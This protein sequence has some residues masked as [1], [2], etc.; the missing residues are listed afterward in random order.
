MIEIFISGSLWQ[1]LEGE[2]KGKDERVKRKKIGTRKAGIRSGGK[3]E[4]TNAFWL[5]SLS[6]ACYA[7]YISGN[8]SPVLF[9]SLC[10][11]N[12]ML[13][14]SQNWKSYGHAWNAPVQL[15]IS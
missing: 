10:H 3:G 14:E 8:T 2:R 12:A 5:H 13:E 1:A 9:P 6:T 11:T 4:K 7:G 15:Q